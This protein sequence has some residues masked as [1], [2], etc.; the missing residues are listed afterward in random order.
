MIR[1]RML[2][3]WVLSTLIVALAYNSAPQDVQRI[4]ITAKRFAFEP[5]DITVK[6]GVPVVLVFHS[7]DVT[8]GI[9]INDLG[10]QANIHKGKETVLKFTPTQPG[11]YHGR[12][13]HFCGKGHGEM[14]FT[15]HVE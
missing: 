5:N 15:V 3:A 10:L 12:C 6:K 1:K 14:T 4:E 7:E 11:T 2:S 9:K 13:S 8:H